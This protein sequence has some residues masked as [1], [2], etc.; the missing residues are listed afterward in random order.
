VGTVD[1]VSN[2]IERYP[3]AYVLELEEFAKAVLADR[4]VAVTG[5]D[6]LAAFMLCQAAQRSFR[7]GG[8]VKLRYTDRDGHVHYEAV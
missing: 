6:G 3:R 8:T 7:E 2:F 4:P 1:Y 5:E